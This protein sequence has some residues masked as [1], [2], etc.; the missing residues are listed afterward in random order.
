MRRFLSFVFT[1]VAVPR[2]D[3][4]CVEYPINIQYEVSGTAAPG[5]FDLTDGALSINAPDTSGNLTFNIIANT[6]APADET[7]VIEVTAATDSGGNPNATVPTPSE[8]TV[9]ITGNNNAPQS[10]PLQ[11][12]QDGL[13]TQ[14]VYKNKWEVTITANSGTGQFSY[15]WSATDPRLPGEATGNQYTFD[16]LDSSVPTPGLTPGAYVVSVEIEGG[17]QTIHQTITLWLGESAPSL[18]CGPD[19][20]AD[21]NGI[22]NEIE[23]Y[24]DFDF[25]GLPDYQDPIGDPSLLNREVSSAGDNQARLITTIA[26]LSLA[27]NGTAVELVANGEATGAKLSADDVIDDPDF[28]TVSSVFDFQIRGL[29]DT[30]RTAQVVIPLDNPIPPGARYR[31][32]INGVWSDFI[33]TSTDGIRSAKSDETNNECPPLGDPLY[34][35][36][37]IAFNDCLELTLTDGGPNDADGEANGVIKDP[38]A[39]VL[40]ASVPSGST[41]SPDASSSPGGAGALD[42]WWLM[43][44]TP[45]LWLPYRL[46]KGQVNY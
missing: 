2:A 46:K 41:T 9:V 37:L 29:S 39:V 21:G 26:G 8:Y 32:L 24:G 16:P 38:G 18:S 13:N 17:Q 43:M 33:E 30:Q 42:W 12:S 1:N 34:R 10:P 22:C 45:L 11:V 40:P 36:E 23:G 5:D 25:D 6:S 28:S 35:D 7:V 20:D 14:Y 31:K 19:D 44:L 15:D 27:L 4:D 3:G